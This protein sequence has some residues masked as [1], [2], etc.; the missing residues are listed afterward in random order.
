MPRYYFKLDCRRP[1]YD[2]DGMELPDDAAARQQR[3]YDRQTVRHLSYPEV[4]L[5]PLDRLRARRFLHGNIERAESPVK[6]CGA[7]GFAHESNMLC[8][9]EYF[10]EVLRTFARRHDD[11]Q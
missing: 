6:I 10:P 8:T 5:E 9:L 3:G 2:E 7:I 1:Y 4:L 11:R